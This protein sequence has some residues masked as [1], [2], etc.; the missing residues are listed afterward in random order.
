MA[1]TSKQIQGD[2]YRL[3]RDST[4]YTQKLLSGEEIGLRYD[5]EGDLTACLVE[6]AQYGSEHYSHTIE[7]AAKVVSQ[8]YSTEMCVRN[9][10]NL[11]KMILDE[12]TN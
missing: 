5:T 11:Y 2:I 12:K 4:L 10:Y 6:V 9:V 8:L 7:T 3:L 1:K